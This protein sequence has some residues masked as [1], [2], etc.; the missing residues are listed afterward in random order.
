MTTVEIT[1]VSGSDLYHR[2]PGQ[3]SP[4]DAY[5]S[6]D[7]ETG[8]LTA[9]TNGEIGNA[10]PMRVRHGHVK[11]WSIAALKA[12]AANALLE[13][14]RPIAERVCE[15]Y[16]RVWDGNNHVAEFSADAETAISEIASL[17]ERA[18][19]KL[20]VW[21]AADWLDGLGSRDTQRR[22]L[23]ITAATTDDQLNPIETRLISEARRDGIDEIEGLAKY[24]RRLRDEAI[25]AQTDS[26]ST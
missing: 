4:Q 9:E 21:D 13:Q 20:Q 11:R 18:D 8:R 3:T 23:E 15:G 19:E 26:A 7:C 2:Y 22:E 10:V 5:V 14:I 17:C 12:D 1:E 24:L 16:E 25:A 6:L